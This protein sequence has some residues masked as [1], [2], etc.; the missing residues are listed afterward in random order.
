MRTYRSLLLPSFCFLSAWLAVWGC[1]SSNAPVRA[2]QVDSPDGNGP[3]GDDDD[4][5]H[6]CTP[7]KPW[8]GPGVTAIVP[9][10]NNT[11][12]VVN[13]DRYVIGAF[14]LSSTDANDPNL[15]K[16]VSW[17]EKGMLSDLWAG[18]PPAVG[19]KPWDDPGVTAAY[20][21]KGTG[22]QVI[23]SQFKRWFHKG[24]DWALTSDPSGTSTNAGKVIEDLGVLADAGPPVED[25]GLA[26]WEGPGITGASF[27]A[28]GSLFVLISKD[29]EWVRTTSD[30]DP[31]KWY[32]MDGGVGGT[33]TLRD[34]KPWDSAPA[35]LGQKPYEGKG[36]TAIFYAGPKLFVFSADRMWATNGTTW[37]TSGM[38]QDMDVWKSAPLVGCGQ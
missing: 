1:Y 34:T 17:H 5:S 15:G 18:A 14:D 28:N 24:N 2:Y 7:R 29:R 11:A 3:G 16:L 38:L 27:N 12:L 35:V 36:V 33:Y 25:G 6:P 19:Y 21:E 32:W 23:I 9:V 4:A 30:P 31:S 20:I 22:N 13:G 37:S 26:P 10:T 8:E